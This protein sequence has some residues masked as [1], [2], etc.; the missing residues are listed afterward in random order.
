VGIVV[1]AVGFDRLVPVTQRGGGIVGLI[2]DLPGDLRGEGLV[3][4]VGGRVG[5]D[6]VGDHA[7]FGALVVVVELHHFLQLRR[8]L[9][10]RL[11]IGLLARRVRKL[12]RCRA[13]RR[14]FLPLCLA[15]ATLL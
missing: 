7:G 8:D 10:R 13:L 4:G 15:L 14:F 12:I 3:V 5:E 9:G 11:G 1:Q 6:L 2:G